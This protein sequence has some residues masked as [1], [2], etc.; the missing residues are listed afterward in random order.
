MRKANG[1]DVDYRLIP[2]IGHYGVYADM[3]KE[4]TEMEIVWFVKYLNAPKP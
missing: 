4:V 1:T 3:F 2:G